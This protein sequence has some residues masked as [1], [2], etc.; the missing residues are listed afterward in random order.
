MGT[1]GSRCR[2]RPSQR[3]GREI[4]II[5]AGRHQRKGWDTLCEDYR[6]RIRRFV[7]VK[8]VPV[9]ARGFKGS[10]SGGV[11]RRRAEARALLTAVPDPAWLVALDEGGEALDSEALA[12]RLAQ[13]RQD[14]PHPIAFVIGSDL[15]LDAAVRDVARQTLSLGPLTLTHELARLVLYEQLYRGLS[16]EAGINYHRGQL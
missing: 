16:I 14:W 1:G 6:R 12:A 8:D 5:W 11:E 2:I 10:S 13:L 9:K 3:M 15:G 7:T 4:H